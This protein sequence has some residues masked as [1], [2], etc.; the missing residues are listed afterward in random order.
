MGTIPAPNIF[1]DAQEISATPQNALQEYARVEQLKQQTA[2]LAQEQQERGLQ[3]EMQRRQL[4]DQDALTK[5]IASYDPTVHTLADI[6]KLVTQNGGSGKA[7]LEAQAGLIQQRQNYMKMSDE[8]FAQEQRK[9]D[10]IEGVHDQV[11]Q[12]PPEQKQTVYQAGLQHLA[13]AGVDVSKEPIQYPGDDAFAQ[14]LAPIRLHSAILAEAEKD[15]EITAKEQEAQAK[16]T[17]AETSAKEFQAKLPGGPLADVNRT[18]FQSYLN[19][20]DSIKFGGP[21]GF[22]AWKA[23]KE[24][25]ATLPVTVRKDVAVA[26]ATQPLKIAQARAEGEARAEQQVNTKRQETSDTQF[27]SAIGADERLN[28]MEKSYTDAVQN[29]NQQ[30]M[31][32]LL[33]DHIGMTLGLQKGARITKD[34]I[35]EAAQSQP[36]LAGLKAK[37][38]SD[39]Y[40]SGVNLSPGQ[41]KQMLDLG[42]SA[43]ENAWGGARDTAQLYGVKEPPQ[44]TAVYNKRDPNA[45]V[46]DNTS[47]AETKTYQGHTYTRSKPTDPWTLKQ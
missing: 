1:Q 16:A 28:R 25:E 6:P 24:A 47:Q 26:Q 27:Q 30:A 45:R 32:A 17:A 20:P 10:L 40:L 13:Q 37:F 4:A 38:D 8:Q 42:Y 7:A 3:M 2:G 9:A 31:L 23:Q 21:A 18:E 11:T 15:R 14:H 35:N 22:A 43:R 34:I 29:H 12:A 33:T 19:S 44:A 36:W 39:G 5:T 46:Y 41:M